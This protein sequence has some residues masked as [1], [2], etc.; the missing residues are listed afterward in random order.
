M[1]WIMLEPFINEIYFPPSDLNFIK[2]SKYFVLK[3]VWFTKIAEWDGKK[4]NQSR[5]A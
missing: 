4:E 2:I 5:I 1:V 3:N